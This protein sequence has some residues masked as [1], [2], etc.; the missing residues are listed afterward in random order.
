LRT[1]GSQSSGRLDLVNR[2][3]QPLNGLTALDLIPGQR[4]V[5]WLGENTE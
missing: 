3:G 4:H 2:L 1:S 5:S